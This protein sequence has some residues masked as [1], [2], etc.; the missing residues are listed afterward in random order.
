MSSDSPRS[1]SFWNALS[2]QGTVV[3]ALVLREL[4]ARYGRDNIGFLWLIFEPLMLA[5]VISV[6]HIFMGGGHGGD[7]HPGVFTLLGYCTFII[8]RGIFN[9]AEGTL[10]SSV[11]LLYHKMVTI[12]DIMLSR[13]ILEALGCFCAYWILLMLFIALGLAHLPARPLYLFAGFALITWWSFGL[14][15]IV[16]GWTFGS[17]TLGRL[18][19]P[20]AYFLIP[21]SGA[22][23][24]LNFLPEPYRTFMSYNPMVL[25]FEVARYGQFES[26]SDK[27]LDFGYI[28]GWTAFFTYVGLIAVARVRDD[29]HLS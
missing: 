21:L 9:K 8:F 11:S 22:F 1:T 3:R 10:E 28:I 20:I 2:L 26:A 12:F 16:T 14:A 17:R 23:W 4:H 19:H 27:Y 25:I 13:A 18:V 7:M 15:L 5:T 24:T 29:V 6:L